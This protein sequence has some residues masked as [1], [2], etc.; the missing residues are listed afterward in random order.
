MEYTSL[1]GTL[2]REL[3]AGAQQYLSTRRKEVD[4]LNV[5]PVPDG[6][7]GTNMLLTLS[8]AVEKLGVERDLDLSKAAERASLGALMGARGNSGVILSQILRGIAKSFSGKDA[9]GPQDV[10]QALNDAVAT[11]YRAVM[12]PVEG[13]MLTVLRGMRD[14]ALAASRSG[15]DIVGILKESVEKGK[16]VLAKTPEMLPVLKQAGVVDAGGKG[17]VLIMEGAL[18]VLSR[19]PEERVQAPSPCEEIRAKVSEQEIQEIRYPYD[20]QF[21]LVG[22]DIPLAELR[23]SLEPYGDSLLVVGSESLVR[24]HIHTDKPGEVLTLCL[25]YGSLSQVTIDNMIE[26]SQKALE[27]R[28]AY[29][30]AS[31]DEK[32]SLK[33]DKASWIS[34]LPAV[35]DVP[36]QGCQPVKETGIVSVATG[37]G[38][39]EIMKSLGCDLVIDGGVTM[40]PSTS[41]LAAAVK[42]VNAR[43]IIFLPNNGNI[44]LAAKQAKKLTGRTMYIIPSK[45]IPQGI[46]ALL[47]LNLNEDMEHNLKRAAKAVKRVKTGEVTFAARNGKF[48]KHVMKE[49]DILGL[50]EGKVEVVGDSPEEVLKTVI[51]G[52]VGKDDSVVTVY[53]GQDSDPDLGMNAIET[54]RREFTDSLEFEFHRGGQPLYYYIVS[55]E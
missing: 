42:T 24:V 39:R 53:Y 33:P 23:S 10:A 9:A 49:G 22:K 4:A 15:C 21:L 2:F 31:G 18:S 47:A 7:T 12:K 16:E 37:D 52:M 51:R 55:V 54:L 19:T 13:T 20:T 25:R 26:Q 44:F 34:G 35:A 14:A 36:V 46:S 38:L 28:T 48:G 50:I 1:D 11:A 17:L 43:R 45:T 40:N 32:P 27:E 6:D 41:E 30:V 8:S 29:A 3:L 5:F